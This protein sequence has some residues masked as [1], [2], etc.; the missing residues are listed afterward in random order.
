[1]NRLAE[2][3]GQEA[4]KSYHGKVMGAESNLHEIAALFPTWSIEEA[5]GLWC[6]AFVLHCC[7]KAGMEIP[8]KP[9]VCRLSLAACP[10]WEEWAMEDSRISRLPKEEDPQAGD[11]VIFDR[12]FCDSDHDHMGIVLEATEESLVV[13]EGNFNNVSCIVNRK[14]DE[15]IR[16]LIRIPENFAY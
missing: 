8:Y 4:R 9:A 6:A 5:D 2:V 14:R 7:R 16:C 1:M 10:A 13:A 15:H 11:L 12:V 3:A